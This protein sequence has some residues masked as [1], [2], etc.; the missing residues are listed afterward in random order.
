METGHKGVTTS[1]P[2]HDITNHNADWHVSIGNMAVSLMVLISRTA[3]AGRQY[4]WWCWFLGLLVKE[5]VRQGFPLSHLSCSHADAR[6][7]CDNKHWG[8]CTTH[9]HC[10]SAQCWNWTPVEFNPAPAGGR[11]GHMGLFMVTPTW[12]SVRLGHSDFLNIVY[13]YRQ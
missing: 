6:L 5:S 9:K 11:S 12:L 2:Q 4:L 10:K 13:T 8:C 7:M 1:L 3:G